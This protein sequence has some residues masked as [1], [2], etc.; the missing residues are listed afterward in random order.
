MKPGP[1]GRHDD[2]LVELAGQLPDRAPRS[3]RRSP[4]PRISSI[5]GMTGTGLKK[6]IPTKRARRALADR[7]GEP[8]DRDRRGVRGEDR[9][10]RGDPVEVGPQRGLD[11]DVLEHG[12]DDE[13]GVGGGR[14]V[15]RGGD[16]GEDRV[17]V[18]GVERLFA[19]AR[20]RLPA[21]RSRPASARASVRLVERDRLPGRG[22]DL[23]DAVAHEPGARHEDPLDRHRAPSL[24]P[25]R[26]RAPVGREPPDRDDERRRRPAA[27]TD[28]EERRAVAR[29]GPRAA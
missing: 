10:G 9:G 7:R 17:A 3:R 13:V 26:P 18:R 16:A 12:L 8:V 22:V 14:E 1:V 29:A 11:V 20:S 6:W 24:S 27:T 4:M 21:I 5:S 2:L 19:T 28:S 15:V 25:R 23:G